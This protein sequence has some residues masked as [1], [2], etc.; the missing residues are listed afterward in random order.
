IERI[1][2]VR[3]PR[4]ARW[5][6]DAIGGV[7]QI[8]TRLPDGGGARAA[9]GRYDDRQLA[10]QVGNGFIG[11]NA[12]ARRTNGFSAQ[13]P[14]G[15]SYDPDNDGFENLSFSARGDHPLG[16]GQLNWSARAAS[17]DVEFDQGETDFLNYALSGSYRQATRGPWT[18]EGSAAFYH[19][20]METDNGFS[21]ADA[22]TRRVQAGF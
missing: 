11:F 22:V 9:Y 17:G 4:A 5:G 1:E 18:W 10:A 6:S 21:I 20:N 15:P 3:G 7:I 2:I 14:S 8:F 13:N 16:D 19:D 12:S